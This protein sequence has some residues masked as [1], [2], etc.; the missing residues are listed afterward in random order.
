MDIPTLLETIAGNES[1][2][3]SCLDSSKAVFN[4][5]KKSGYADVAELYT[6]KLSDF[7]KALTENKGSS[8]VAVYTKAMIDI[9][10]KVDEIHALLN[11]E[12]HSTAISKL[13]E[14]KKGASASKK[15]RDQAV[16]LPPEDASAAPDEEST[17]GEEEEHADDNAGDGL[18]DLWA[19]LAILTRSNDQLTRTIETLSKTNAVLA[20]AAKYK[21][22]YHKLKQAFLCMTSDH[23]EAMS[24]LLSLDE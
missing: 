13:K 17:E 7:L 6:S 15:P 3:K 9:L 12:E 19:Q 14:I 5:A 8:T 18:G 20:E 2:P 1:I 16:T 21:L 11:D 23:K 24:M 10:S 4:F 22:K